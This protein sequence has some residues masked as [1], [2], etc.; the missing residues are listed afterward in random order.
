MRLILLLCLLLISPLLGADEAPP[1][2]KLPPDAVKALAKADADIV[3]IRRALIVQLQK[4]QEAATK[5][6]DLDGA[7]AV[8]GKIEEIGK[9][10]PGKAAPAPVEATTVEYQGAFIT[11]ATYG[12]DA[13]S[14]DCMVLIKRILKGETLAI[15]NNSLGFDPVPN[16]PKHITIKW[17]APGGKACTT[18]LEEGRPLTVAEIFS[19]QP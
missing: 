16:Q 9:D 4:S 11:K 19:V 8:K 3:A 10:L 2:V 18:F 5:K 12:T 14:V 1:P 7:L 13:H 6:G 17:I 15:D